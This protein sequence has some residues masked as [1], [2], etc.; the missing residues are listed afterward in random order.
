MPF[1][2]GDYYMIEFSGILSEECKKYIIK[3]ETRLGLIASSLAM[4]ILAIFSILAA[5]FIAWYYILFLILPLV[6][7]PTV[8]I[9]GVPEKSYGL[10]MPTQI[11]IENIEDGDA[12]MTSRGKEFEVFAYAS[13]VKEVMD[14]G[15]WYYI[16]FEF[17]YRNQRFVCQKD[18]I[19]QGT[20]EEF[21]TLFADKIIRKEAN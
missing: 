17:A 4:G 14:F 9:V 19:T 20:I 2:E 21:E 8:C 5:I 3:N 10:I 16:T 15:E 7:M 18:L 12:A 6:W 11:I 1:L 13:A